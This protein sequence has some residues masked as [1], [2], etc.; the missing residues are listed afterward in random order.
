MKAEEWPELKASIEHG[1]LVWNKIYPWDSFIS[2][3]ALTRDRVRE[4]K[5]EGRTRPEIAE[6]IE[7]E[8]PELFEDDDED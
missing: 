3:D 1:K 2:D 5:A 4:L 8:Y 7:R 6:I